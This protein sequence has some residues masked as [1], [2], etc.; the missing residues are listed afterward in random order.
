MSECRKYA[1][2]ASMRWINK[3]IITVLEKE[4][5]PRID[6]VHKKSSLK[7]MRRKDNI[8]HLMN[9][10]AVYSCLSSQGIHK[11]LLSSPRLLI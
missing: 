2:H 6:R 5:Y 11:A 3:K 4:S 7:I 1:H 8:T 9:K 10:L